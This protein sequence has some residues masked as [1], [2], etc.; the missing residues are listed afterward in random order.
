MNDRLG[1]NTYQSFLG[2]TRKKNTYDSIGNIDCKIRTSSIITAAVLQQKALKGCKVFF[3]KKHKLY[4]RCAVK[5]VVL[6]VESH[7]CLG[8]IVAVLKKHSVAISTVF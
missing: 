5:K 7:L 1:I 4:H 8:N 2:S 6:F 3:E